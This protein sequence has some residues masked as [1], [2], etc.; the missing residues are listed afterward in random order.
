MDHI[1]K[2]TRNTDA[3]KVFPE[4]RIFQ[5]GA[6]HGNRPGQRMRN[7]GERIQEPFLIRSEGIGEVYFS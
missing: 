4:F 2:A 3:Y 5:E 1:Q 6:E 7:K